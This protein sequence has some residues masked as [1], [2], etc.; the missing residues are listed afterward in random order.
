MPG[1]AREI[2]VGVIGLGFMGRTHIGAYD[3]AARDGLGVRLAGVFDRDA[4]RLTGEAGG[5]GNIGG[6]Q[7]ERL[8]DP[9]RVFATDDLDALLAREDID[10]VSVCTPTDSHVEIAA[11][12]L[13]AGKHV[14]VEKPVSLEV[15]EIERLAGEATRAGRVCMPAM[16]MRFWP[17]W[18]WLAD[19]IRGGASDDTGPLRA[20]SLERL[21]TMPGWGGGFYGDPTRSG[22]A[23]FDLHIHD[24]DFICGAIGVPEA[25]TSVGDSA[26]VATI[27]HYG[28]ER[29]GLNVS[30]RGGWLRGPGF[31]F[32]MRYV[33]EFERGVADFDLGGQPTSLRWC[34]SHADDAEQMDLGGA[35]GYDGE[36]RAFLRAVRG[37]EP[38]AVTLADAA[39]TTRVLL[40]ERR[41]IG[42]RQRERIQ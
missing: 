42:S 8:F 15:D 30:A 22:G 18:S 33:A 3:A 16:C 28:G 34:A 35:T 17:E 32:R 27:Y 41:S 6:D 12:A 36:V 23:L 7:P 4:G 37:E 5:G 24:T 13:R 9:A 31:G 10:A 20:V 19:G 38:P 26:H 29:A 2:G 25:V 39:A 40:A 21:G 14:L 1:S 11:R